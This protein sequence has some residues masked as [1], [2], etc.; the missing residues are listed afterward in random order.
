MEIPVRR[1]V[2]TLEYFFIFRF[3]L[4]CFKIFDAST[5]KW[6]LV[7][8]KQHTDVYERIVENP[9]ED[10]LLYR[11]NITDETNIINN[12]E[13]NLLREKFDER[14]TRTK[15][16]VDFIRSDHLIDESVSSSD[17]VNQVVIKEDVKTKKD[18]KVSFGR[19]LMFVINITLIHASAEKDRQNIHNGINSASQGTMHL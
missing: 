10:D 15:D 6:K 13:R 18:T 4:F 19:I 17:L 5:N 16:S 3:V 2:C 1:Y 9:I 8:E 12:L 7:D 11:R 14:H